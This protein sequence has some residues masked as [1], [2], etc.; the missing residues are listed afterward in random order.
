MA[1]DPQCFFHQIEAASTTRESHKR[2]GQNE[3]S[4]A[5]CILFPKAQT[6]SWVSTRLQISFEHMVYCLGINLSSVD[7]VE[8]GGY[9]GILPEDENRLIPLP[10]R[11]LINH[12][13][14]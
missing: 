7:W 9:P 4:T 12:G 14:N 1:H 13:G 6:A 3:R 2:R 11:S 5:R 8:A 10:L